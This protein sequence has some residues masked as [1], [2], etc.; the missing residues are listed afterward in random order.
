MPKIDKFASSL[1]PNE[2]SSNQRPEL[3]EPFLTN[4]SLYN[5][6]IYIQTTKCD[7][8]SQQEQKYRQDG[9]AGTL[10]NMSLWRRKPPIIWIS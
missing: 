1:N 3:Y 2:K 10:G 6:P 4:R 5:T 8:K 7:R 9:I